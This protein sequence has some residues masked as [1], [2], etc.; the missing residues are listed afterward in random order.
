MLQI[1]TQLATYNTTTGTFNWL[2]DNAPVSSDYLFT[3]IPGQYGWEGVIYQGSNLS[4]PTNGNDIA[5]FLV[6][7]LVFT[8]YIKFD[9]WSRLCDLNT[10]LKT[11]YVMIDEMFVQLD[12]SNK[13]VRPNIKWL[14]NYLLKAK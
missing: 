7:G 2:S 13:N 14:R 9:Q 11:K 1:S 3:F 4:T 5:S 6:H 12:F 8:K 10:I